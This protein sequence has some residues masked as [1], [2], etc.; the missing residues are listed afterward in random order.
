MASE[1]VSLFLSLARSLFL[2]LW[3][4][5]FPD[6]RLYRTLNRDRWIPDDVSHSYTSRMTRRFRL[7]ESI[8]FLDSFFSE[9]SRLRDLNVTGSTTPTD[10]VTL[11]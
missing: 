2:A 10:H 3:Q 9:A 11:T 4:T 7:I 6:V 8:Q 5:F 1:V